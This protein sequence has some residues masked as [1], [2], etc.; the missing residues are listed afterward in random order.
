MLENIFLWNLILDK[1]IFEKNIA[2]KNIFG[3]NIFLGKGT[4]LSLPPPTIH[5]LQNFHLLL[6]LI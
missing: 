2:A 1:N 5:P 3:K 6:P 4:L